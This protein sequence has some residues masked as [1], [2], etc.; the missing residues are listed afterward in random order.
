VYLQTVS[1]R[2]QQVMQETDGNLLFET[3]DRQQDDPWIHRG[4]L[5]K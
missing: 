5:T 3:R 1:E 4:Y 2:V